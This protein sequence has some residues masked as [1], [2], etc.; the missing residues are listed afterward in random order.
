MEKQRG[1][2]KHA[3]LFIYIFIFVDFLIFCL[4]FLFFNFFF[5]FTY[6]KVNRDI[7]IYDKDLFPLGNRKC[8]L[9]LF[10]QTNLP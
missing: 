3:T 8:H 1:R 2:D 4:F 7:I 5:F 9:G 10:C 6:N